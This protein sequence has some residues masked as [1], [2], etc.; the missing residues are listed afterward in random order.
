MKRLTRI[1]CYIFGCRLDPYSAC[2]RCGEQLYDYPG[3]HDH[4][5]EAV[6]VI[7]KLTRKVR[8][9]AIGKKCVVCGK[10]YWT[11]HDERCCSREC[12]NKW[13]PF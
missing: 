7:Q 3:I 8:V 10:R 4:P 13:I 2:D 12:F 6:M 9:V 1:W 5:C 11:G